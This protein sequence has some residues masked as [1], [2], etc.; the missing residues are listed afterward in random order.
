MYISSTPTCSVQNSA[1]VTV[2]Y[3]A[4]DRNGVLFCCVFWGHRQVRHAVALSFCI[5]WGSDALCKCMNI[6]YIS[7]YEPRSYRKLS[8]TACRTQWC[9]QNKQWNNTQILSGTVRYEKCCHYKTSN[10]LQATLKWVGIT[11]MLSK[12]MIYGAYM[13]HNYRQ[14]SGSASSSLQWQIFVD[15]QFLLLRNAP[16]S[17]GTPWQVYTRSCWQFQNVSQLAD[18][19]HICTL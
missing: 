18:P 1:W 7:I 6:W 19:Q 4:T 11:R 12:P 10:C 2:T 15:K 16:C 3:I 17:M 13:Q 9:T 14:G 8:T 5:G